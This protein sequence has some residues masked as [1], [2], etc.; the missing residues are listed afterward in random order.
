MLIGRNRADQTKCRLPP[1][2]M[3][4]IA[5]FWLSGL[6]IL[7][8]IFTQSDSHALDQLNLYLFISLCLGSL[9]GGYLSDQFDRLKVFKAFTAVWGV[10]CVLM[11]VSPWTG[12]IVSAACIGLLNNLTFVIVMEHFPVDKEIYTVYV[13][14]GWAAS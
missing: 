6:F 1:Q 4:L 8:I 14:I 13:L 2:L 9:L 7:S 5:G 3:V 11:P 12:Y 10:S